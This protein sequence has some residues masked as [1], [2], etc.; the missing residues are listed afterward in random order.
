MAVMTLFHGSDHIIEQPL[1]GGGRAHN[2]YGQG[3]YCTEHLEMAKEWAVGGRRDGYANRYTLDT[4]GLTMLDLNSDRYT[5]LHWMAVLLQNRVFDLPAALPFEA[6]A[7]LIERFPVPYREADI[8]RGYRADDAYFSFA[9]DFLN[10][11]I[12]LRQLSRAMRLG[13]L[14]EQVVLKSEEAFGRAAFQ[15]AEFVSRDEWFPRYS[16]RDRRARREYFD[17]E[18]QRREPGDLYILQILDEEVGPDDPRLR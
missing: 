10:G 13:S 3:F 8:I 15:G 4:E 1:F 5:I 7:Y 12:S 17:V 16:E 18:R 9:Q 14:G 2:D 11:L 6:R